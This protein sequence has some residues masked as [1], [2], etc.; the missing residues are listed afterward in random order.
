[1]TQQRA[2]PYNS[3]RIMATRGIKVGV[4]IFLSYG[5]SYRI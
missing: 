4:E 1:L 5:K 3:G 2:H